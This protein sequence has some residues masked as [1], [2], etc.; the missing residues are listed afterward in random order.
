MVFE[1]RKPA[2]VSSSTTLPTSKS[3]WP[4]AKVLAA[5]AALVIPPL[6]IS[7][8]RTRLHPR[9]RALFQFHPSNEK[10]LELEEA[11]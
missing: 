5:A 1:K 4:V 2:C 6:K 3:D 10:D 9:P 11:I 7:G 8:P